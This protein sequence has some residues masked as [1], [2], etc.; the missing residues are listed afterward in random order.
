MDGLFKRSMSTLIDSELLNNAVPKTDFFSE[1]S[2]QTI[3][4]PFFHNNLRFMDVS[5]QIHHQ[6]C[7]FM[8]CSNG[9]CS[10]TTIF[11]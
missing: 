4:E 3:I 11:F 5:A 8:C 6:Q 2:T 7:C 10:A 9:N 1:Y